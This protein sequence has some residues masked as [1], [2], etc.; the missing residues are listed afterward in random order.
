MCSFMK[1]GMGRNL[2][3]LKGWSGQ[4][5]NLEENAIQSL[6]NGGFQQALYSKDQ[7]F[8]FYKA[9]EQSVK[10]FKCYS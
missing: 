9:F 1:K 7:Y 2:K 6:Q 5:H 4:K 10:P 3:A 8:E